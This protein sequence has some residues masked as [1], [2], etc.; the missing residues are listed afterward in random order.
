MGT[1]VRA[2]LGWPDSACG[3]GSSEG[4]HCVAT[5]PRRGEGRLQGAGAEGLRPLCAVNPGPGSD[6]WACTCHPQSR[7]TQSQAGRSRRLLW[8]A[9]R[10]TATRTGAGHLGVH[11]APLSRGW[12]CPRL[13]LLCVTAWPPAAHGHVGRGPGPGRMV[14]A[15]RKSSFCWSLSCWEDRMERHGLLNPV[16]PTPPSP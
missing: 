12:L 6:P 3:S 4:H 9:A 16:Q 2:K 11:R 13:T 14:E 7:K 5:G 10:G 8:S 1:P 15:A